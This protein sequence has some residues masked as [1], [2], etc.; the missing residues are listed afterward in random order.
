[1]EWKNLIN[2][3]VEAG[4][5]IQKKNIPKKPEKTKEPVKEPEPEKEPDELVHKQSPDVVVE[6]EVISAHIKARKKR[7]DMQTLEW[8]RERNAGFQIGRI[9]YP[10]PMFYTA[11]GHNVKLE[12][13]ARGSSVLLSG[14]NSKVG[15]QG[16]IVCVN[17]Y[18]H[19]WMTIITKNYNNKEN[20]KVLNRADSIKLMPAEFARMKRSDTK[21]VSHSPNCFYFVRCD[22]F[23]IDQFFMEDAFCGAGDDS[24]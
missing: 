24:C 16:Q 11:D 21:L 17:N 6:N 5:K 20:Y 2:K 9:W 15:G 23:K 18:M 1:M 19:S 4:I 8:G 3:R 22:S 14:P 7:S 12:D 10:V 13:M